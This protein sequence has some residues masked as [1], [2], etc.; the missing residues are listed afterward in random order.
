VCLLSIARRIET[1]RYSKSIVHE[2]KYFGFRFG[3]KPSEK[4][5]LK[6]ALEE[7]KEKLEKNSRRKRFLR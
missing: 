7:E 4:H 2:K 6:F 1:P 3:K 5:V